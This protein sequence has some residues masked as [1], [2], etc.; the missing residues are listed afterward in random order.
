[1]QILK[2]TNSETSII[3]TS[4][5][6][7]NKINEKLMNNINEIIDDRFETVQKYHRQN[8]FEYSKIL[9]SQ[10]CMTRYIPPFSSGKP[11]KLRPAESYQCYLY[12]TI[13][14]LLIH[15][16]MLSYVCAR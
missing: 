16:G 4:Y 11:V 13:L 6:F 10:K 1:V 8:Y 9:K 5:L 7:W 12:S 14:L 15:L 3:D 2:E